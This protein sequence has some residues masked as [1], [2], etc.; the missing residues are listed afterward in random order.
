[1]LGDVD[2]TRC[3]ELAE[4]VSRKETTVLQTRISAPRAKRKK[5]RVLNTYNLQF[6]HGLCDLQRYAKIYV[7]CHRQRMA[8]SCSK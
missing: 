4:T 1:L 7:F 3:S 8:K 5:F 2:M 6:S